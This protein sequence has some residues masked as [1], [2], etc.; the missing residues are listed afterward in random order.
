[1]IKSD[2]CRNFVIAG[3]AGCGK[4]TLCDLMLFKSG[5]VERMGRV[6][7]KTSVSD[8]TAEEQQREA[9]LFASV[10]HCNWKN[11]RFFFIDTPGYGEFVGQYISAVRAA[12]ARSRQL[13][14]MK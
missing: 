8:Y 6:S 12:T 4:T 7:A 2:D 13:G 1:M 5:T 11:S 14:E 3:H 9:S 10:M